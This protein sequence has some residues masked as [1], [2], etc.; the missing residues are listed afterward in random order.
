MWSPA[1]DVADV[2]VPDPPEEGDTIDVTKLGE[3]GTGNGGY[4]WFGSSFVGPGNRLCDEQGHFNASALPTSAIDKVAF[5][6]DADYFNTTDVSKDHIW[7][8]D[9]KAIQGALAVSDPYLGNIATALGLVVKR[10]VDLADEFLTGNHTAI[11]PNKPNTSG[12]HFDPAPYL[13]AAEL[14]A[15]H[16]GKQ[17]HAFSLFGSSSAGA[18]ELATIEQ[19]ATTL[20]VGAIQQSVGTTFIT[21][22]CF[23]R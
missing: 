22:L 14:K 6:H 10:G 2:D 12:V 5:Q 1:D 4:T 20:R 3:S 11:Y 7:E 23:R 19:I 17:Q 9:K 16:H 13:K 21:P 8:L 15:S 18:A